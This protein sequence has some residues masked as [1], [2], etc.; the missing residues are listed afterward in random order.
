MAEG[1]DF[2]QIDQLTKRYGAVTVLDAVSLTVEE[3][4]FL[5]VLGPSGSGKTTILRV[6]GG[7]T[8]PSGGRILFGGDDVTRQP[9]NQRPFNTVFQDYALFPHMT[10]EQNVA[11]GLM[12]RGVVKAKIPSAVA[13]SLAMVAM[14]GFAERYPTQLSGGQQQRVAL[15]RALICRPRLILLD[16]PLAAL[17]AALRRQMRTFLKSLQ[18]N[19]G[20]T[21]VFVTHDQEEAISMSDRICV[22]DK[23]KIEQ[24][25]TP[26]DIYYRPATQFV[27]TFFGDNNLFRGRFQ[28]SGPDMVRVDAVCGPINVRNPGFGPL[29]SG[30]AI[31]VAVRPEALRIVDVASDAV[32]DSNKLAGRVESVEF[33]GPM[34]HIWVA[35]EADP[36]HPLLLKEPS[37]AGAR[38][39]GQGDR[40]VVAWR[41]EDCAILPLT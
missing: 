33:V 39:V 30:K 23:G 5:T 31:T 11:Y 24:V 21:F 8:E 16:E 9:I 41:P 19:I 32:G 12:V 28:Q 10:V 6:V 25:G 18:R 35:P 36:E 15:A 20:I 3:G 14:E 7:F 40:V 38:A 37:L 2:L 4:E 1:A 17:D 26:H 27:A 34:S 22:I 13:D 29:H